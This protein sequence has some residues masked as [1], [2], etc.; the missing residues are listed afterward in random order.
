MQITRRAPGSVSKWLLRE[1]ADSAPA[2]LFCLPYS[3]CGAAMYRGWPRYIGHIEVCPVQL[4][5]RDSRFAEPHFGTYQQLA[6]Q[7]IEG[8]GPYLDRPFALFGHCGSALPAY[9]M[10]AQLTQRGGPLP[11]HL[12]VSSQVAPHDGPYG[13]LLGLTDA[14]LAAEVRALMTEL[15]AIVTDDLVEVYVEVL[16]AD[17]EANKRYQRS[18]VWLAHPITAIGWDADTEVAPDLM[19]SWRDCG[20]ARLTVLR[21]R[22]YQFLKPTG[23]LLA[24]LQASLPVKDSGP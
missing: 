20:D 7:L 12:V 17:I 19:R 6:A 24:V 2:R 13:R 16:R 5:G 14:E 3:G 23:E 9:E 4:P 1:P 15:R 10:S 18:P 21:G 11:G 22:H 8:L